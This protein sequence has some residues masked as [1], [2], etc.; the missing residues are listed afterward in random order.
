MQLQELEEAYTPDKY[1]AGMLSGKR[2]GNQKVCAHFNAKNR[3]R[4]VRLKYRQ[5]SGRA[6]GSGPNIGKQTSGGVVKTQEPNPKQI[7]AQGTR[8]MVSHCEHDRN[9][10]I[11]LK[12]ETEKQR[13]HT[14]Q[15]QGTM[16]QQPGP[17]QVGQDKVQQPGPVPPAQPHPQDTSP[18][19]GLDLAYRQSP[20]EEKP[21]LRPDGT[22]KALT[23]SEN[24]KKNQ[25]SSATLG[26]TT[27]RV[28]KS[29]T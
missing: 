29:T 20:H 11:G 28:T 18:A 25:R 9:N 14:A 7:G 13:P 5:D 12:N 1:L 3:G 6:C 2:Q 19:L 27:L 24:F 16:S 23:P 15:N 8:T 17:A 22:L 4:F 10:K 21:G 26:A